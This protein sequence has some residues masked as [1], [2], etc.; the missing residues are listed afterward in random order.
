MMFEMEIGR[1]Y[2]AIGMYAE[3][4]KVG[5]NAL[6][7]CEMIIKNP[8]LYT[9]EQGFQVQ[10]GSTDEEALNQASALARMYAAEAAKIAGKWDV[11]LRYLKEF[12]SMTGRSM[13][14]EVKIDEIEVL[15][16]LRAKD[17]YGALDGA[18]RMRGK[19]GNIGSEMQQLIFE[20][21]RRLGREQQQLSMAVT[22]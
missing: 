15:K 10:P 21:Q 13:D 2:N 9:L 17:F 22:P 18:L 5:M 19:Y 12:G 11:A 4:E 16:K 7:S 20:L 3:S 1:L 6:K 14:L 8:R